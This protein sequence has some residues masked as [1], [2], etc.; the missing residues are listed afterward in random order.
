M[1]RQFVKQ[2]KELMNLHG[3]RLQKWCTG[4]NK[5]K[6]EDEIRLFR[7]YRVRMNAEVFLYLARVIAV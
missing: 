6:W 7:D 3:L 4:K 2:E 5:Q 1:W